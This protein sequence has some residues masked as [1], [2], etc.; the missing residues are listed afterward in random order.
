MTSSSH[1]A[2]EGAWG[3]QARNIGSPNGSGSLG[4]WDD[5]IISSKRAPAASNKK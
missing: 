2:S 3:N 1:W 5:A 4:F